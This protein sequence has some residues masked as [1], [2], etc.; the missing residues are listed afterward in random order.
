[1][2]AFSSLKTV[3]PLLL[4]FCTKMALG[5]IEPNVFLYEEQTEDATITHELKVDSGYLIYTKFKQQPPEFISTVGGFYT[6]ENDSIKVKLEFNSDYEKNTITNVAMGYTAMGDDLTLNGNTFKAVPQQKQDLDGQWLFATR[7]PD[8]GQERRGEA[9]ARKTL[10]FLLNGHFQWIAYHTETFRFSGTG[11]GAFSS[12]DGKYIE[13]I[14]YFS[15]DNNRVG[16][17]LDFNY[18]VKGADWHHTGKNSK[19][20]PMYEIW[21]RR[22]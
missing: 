6:L 11:G 4:L 10:K 3:I 17:K 2:K 18:E 15:R 13:N 8:T 16:A 7:G 20:A 1:M 21:A 22:D 12:K 9:Q 5:Q 14:G 19:G